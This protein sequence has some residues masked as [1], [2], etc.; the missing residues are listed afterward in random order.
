[1][2]ARLSLRFECR[3]S[4]AALNQADG[5]KTQSGTHEMLVQSALLPD[6]QLDFFGADTAV[7]ALQFL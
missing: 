7:Y 6:E 3:S 4:W 2:P 1:M 5:I